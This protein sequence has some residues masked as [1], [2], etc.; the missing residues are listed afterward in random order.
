[1]EQEHVKV[2]IDPCDA[3]ILNELRRTPGTRLTA[4]P[5]C[6]RCGETSLVIDMHLHQHGLIVPRQRVPLCCRCRDAAVALTPPDLRDILRGLLQHPVCLWPTGR[7][8]RRGESFDVE[9]HRVPVRADFYFEASRALIV[10]ECNAF[11]DPRNDQVVP[12]HELEQKIGHRIA[13]ALN[14]KHEAPYRAVL[15]ANY[16]VAAHPLFIKV[17]P[18]QHCNMRCTFCSNPALQERRHLRL[19]RFASLWSQLDPTQIVK[20][21]FTGLGESL[22][23]NDLWDMHAIVKQHGIF[24]TLVTNGA[25]LRRKASLIVD[26][27]FDAVAVSIES[28]DAQV[29]SSG[30][31]GGRLEQVLD[32]LAHLKALGARRPTVRVICAV[33]PGMHHDAITVIRYCRQ[34]GLPPP[35]V[36]PVYTRFAPGIDGIEFDV[37][38]TMEPIRDALLAAYGERG[39]PCREEYLATLLRAGASYTDLACSEPQ[40]TFVIRAD[41]S[42]TCCNE[43]IFDLDDLNQRRFPDAGLAKAWQSSHFRRRRLSLYLRQPLSGCARCNAFTIADQAGHAT[44]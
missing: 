31:I 25:L 23:N 8:Q 3:D 43:A 39:A 42:Y 29:Y 16:G 6:R 13:S 30:R 24:T 12:S 33:K 41:G 18:T 15:S 26:A 19:G 35:K 34:L 37:Q 14:A 44:A 20:V 28:M 17:E 10:A 36:Y 32:G 40:R 27:G 22:L 2:E 7:I 4:G 11:L 38:S 1:M 9:G 5:T 21:G